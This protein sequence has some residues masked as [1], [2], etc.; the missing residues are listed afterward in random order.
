[1]RYR[2]GGAD[3]RLWSRTLHSSK[4]SDI[5]WTRCMAAFKVCTAIRDTHSISSCLLGLQSWSGF[6][7]LRDNRS[8]S[9]ITGWSTEIPDSERIRYCWRTL[10]VTNWTVF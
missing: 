8:Y 7:A 5:R 3:D 6:H 1:M 4:T 10:L 9:N 2:A